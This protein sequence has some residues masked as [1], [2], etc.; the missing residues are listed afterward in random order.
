MSFLLKE[1]LL[2]RGDVASRTFEFQ[3]GNVEKITWIP[4]KVNLAD[5]LTKKYSTLTDVLELVI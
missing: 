1:N 4:G 2:I 3:R 5:A